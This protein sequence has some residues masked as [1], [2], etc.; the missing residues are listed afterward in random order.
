MAQIATGSGDYET[1]AAEYRTVVEQYPASRFREKAAFGLGQ[2]EYVAGAYD[3]AARAFEEFI[4]GYPESPLYDE[5]LRWLVESLVQVGQHEEATRRTAELIAR[6]PQHKDLPHLLY[7]QGLSLYKS[8]RI[9][10]MRRPLEELLSRFPRSRYAPEALYW[11]AWQD[12]QAGNTDQAL[13]EFERLVKEYPASNHL[14]AAYRRL[15]TGYMQKQ[16]FDQALPMLLAMLS[17]TEEVK[18]IGPEVFFQLAIHASDGGRHEDAVRILATVAQIHSDPAVEERALVEMGREL[19]LLD[20]WQEALECAERLLSKFPQTLFVPEAHW[21]RAKAFCG[22]DRLD[23][24]AKAFDE[25]LQAL[26]NVG[27]TDRFFEATV[28]LDRGK[29]LEARGLIQEALKEYL[30]V[31]ILFPGPKTSPEAIL[32]GAD[33]Q[34]RLGKEKEAR[35]MLERLVQTY[36]DAPEAQQARLRLRDLLSQAE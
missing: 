33:I 16:K 34:K 1:A 20:R 27:S 17:N 29:L 11:L 23:E 31:D 32:R 21:I 8:G 18:G 26:V 4:T 19:I 9:E 30:Y 3:R 2:A 36:P 14:Y 28:H 6:N 13:Q 24:A 22:M 10:E 15:V 12:D 7:S 35:D 5:A 25:S